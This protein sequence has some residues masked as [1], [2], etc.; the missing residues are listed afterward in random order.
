V[1]YYD[2]DNIYCG[3]LTNQLALGRPGA[4][5]QCFILTG[6]AAS[7]TDLLEAQGRQQICSTL[8]K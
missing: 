2:N 1:Y 6:N 4:A 3:G 8:I 7:Q 5:R